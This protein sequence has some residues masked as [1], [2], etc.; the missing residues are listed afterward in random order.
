MAKAKS[1]TRIPDETQREIE[2]EVKEAP[3]VL[4]VFVK[5]RND[6]TLLNIA[7]CD[8]NKQ[9]PKK[10]ACEY[11][12]SPIV[13][14]DQKLLGGVRLGVYIKGLPLFRNKNILFVLDY[15]VD[16]SILSNPAIPFCNRIVLLHLQWTNKAFR[17]GE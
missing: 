4:D 17:G 7:C 3:D 2:R 10:A 8:M 9:S 6:R 16:T 11:V 13:T 15:T 12:R 14:V 1:P 5:L